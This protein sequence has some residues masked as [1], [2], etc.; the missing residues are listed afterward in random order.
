MNMS[1]K[2]LFFFFVVSVAS[3][4]SV[5]PESVVLS[6]AVGERITDMQVSHESFISEYFN[7]T[8][9]RVEQYIVNQYIPDT[10]E[11]YIDEF[12][13]VDLIVNPKPFSDEQEERLK[14]ELRL[15]GVSNN[16]HQAIVGAVSSAF[17]DAERGQIAL[18]FA[19]FITLEVDKYKKPILRELKTQEKNT[20]REIRGAY[21]E[22]LAMQSTVTAH[23]DSINKVTTEQNLILE[24]L[25]I[26]KQRDEAID[27]AVSINDFLLEGISKGEDLRALL[28]K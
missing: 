27:K 4:A 6:K 15:A 21:A 22:L 14:R 2:A 10:L 25:N 24:K 20:L 13:M 5:P 9:Q 28:E 1:K 23:L 3:C 18:E 7:L 26:L 16:S 8:T 17:G 19:E 11:K 12:N